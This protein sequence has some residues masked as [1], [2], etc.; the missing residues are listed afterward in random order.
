MG[1]RTNNISIY[2]IA[3]ELGVSVATVSR[4]I[5]NKTG[6]SEAT[7]LRVAE[8]LRKNK[9][10]PNHPRQPKQKIA[11]IIPSHQGIAAYEAR[12]L[13]GIYGYLNRCGIIAATLTCNPAE[14]SSILRTVR[15]QQCSGI[16][17]ILPRP[18]MHQFP[19]LEKSKLPI[20]LI[21]SQS[22]S[23][24]IGFID[25]DACLAGMIITCHLLDLGHRKIG[26]ITRWEEN[27]NHIQRYSGYR[28]AM[29]E[30]GIEPRPE[31][32]RT[33]RHS[34]DYTAG[35]S[36][37][38]LFREIIAENPDLTALI[39]V[40]EEI[41]LGAMHEAI[42]SGFRVPEDLSIAGFD[43]SAYSTYTTPSLTSVSHPAREAG[44]KAAEAVV[45][46]L[47][48]ENTGRLVREILPTHLIPGTSTGPVPAPQDR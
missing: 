12:V 25:N 7:R 33:W 27:L 32:F 15:E 23:P 41:A 9:F 14:E 31:W 40:N 5:N 26:F 10:K 24:Q 44:Q 36:G 11:V 30:A 45:A 4:V 2:T 19:E 17:V 34:D 21:D 20:M 6:V 46:F 43:S 18:F 1:H 13:T 35:E 29:L 28:N 48:G 42:A 22:T 3:A 39:A 8:V 16:I 38:I 37:S 47:K